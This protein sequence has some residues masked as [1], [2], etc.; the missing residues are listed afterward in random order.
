MNRLRF[1]SAMPQPYG[2]LCVGIDPPKAVVIDVLIKLP[3]VL[4][5]SPLCPVLLIHLKVAGRPK[6]GRCITL[7]SNMRTKLASGS[8]AIASVYCWL[9]LKN[10]V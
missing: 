6:R 1:G 7:V 5:Y 8:K 4:T 2:S 3:V 9:S 10:P